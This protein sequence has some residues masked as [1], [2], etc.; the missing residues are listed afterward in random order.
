MK[1]PRVT[2]EPDL[3]AVR[4]VYAELE[5]RPAERSCVGRSDCCRFRLTGETPYVTLPEALLA[6]KAWRGTGRRELRLP[7]DGACPM[8][9]PTSGRCLVYASRPFACRTH[10]CKAAGGPR[11]RAAVRDLIQRLETLDRAAGGQGC[12][13]RMEVALRAASEWGTGRGLRR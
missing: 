4:A 8:L 13:Q 6:W 10:F 1:K 3:A 2:L 12:G 9:D 7:E 11:D 5:Q